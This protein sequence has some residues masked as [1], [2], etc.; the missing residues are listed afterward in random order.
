MDGQGINKWTDGRVY[1]GTWQ[2][3]KKHGHGTFTN[4]TGITTKGVWDEGKLS[5]IIE[6]K[7]SKEST[8][9]KSS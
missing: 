3:G 5:Q 2:N 8:N 9:P 7:S 4:K 1:K 6:Q